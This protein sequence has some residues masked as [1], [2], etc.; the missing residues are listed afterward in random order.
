MSEHN[1]RGKLL[2]MLG[3]LTVLGTALVIGLLMSAVASTQ[4]V[5]DPKEGGRLDITSVELKHSD[6]RITVRV[7]V[8][9]RLRPGDL[10]RGGRIFTTFDTADGTTHV[11]AVT[12]SRRG[13]QASL[14]HCAPEGCSW[15]DA[16]RAGRS[17]PRTVQFSVA[18][19]EIPGLADRIEWWAGAVSGDGGSDY[20]PDKGARVHHF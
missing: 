10:T 18:R 19:A 11:L 9:H 5:K 14:G 15:S 6:E 20:A 17:G 12:K 7:T 13:L 3:I 8:A 4:V 16:G 2:G 1:A